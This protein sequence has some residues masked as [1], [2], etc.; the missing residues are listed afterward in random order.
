MKLPKWD[1]KPGPPDRQSNRLTHSPTAPPLVVF[2]VVW[3]PS[4]DTRDPSVVFQGVDVQEH[5]TVLTKL[6]MSM[7]FVLSLTQILIFLSLYVMLTI[8]LSILVCAAASLFCACVL[9]PFLYTT[10]HSWQLSSVSSG[11]WQGCF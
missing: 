8:L 11:R 3:S 9:S 7:T 6:I 5:C 10:C 4:G 1:S 2:F